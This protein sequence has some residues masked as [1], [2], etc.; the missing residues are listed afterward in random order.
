MDIEAWL[1]EDI[2]LGDVTTDAIV[3]PTHAGKGVV[4]A[5]SPLV[6]SG[7]DLLQEVFSRLSKDVRI[8]VH[9]QN[10]EF[11]AAGTVVADVEG[12]F[13]ALL[14][15]ERLALNLMM[16]LSGIATST[17]HAVDALAGSKTR[18]LDTRKTTPGLRALE[19]RAVRHGGGVNHRFG[20]FDGV[21]IKDNH[22][23]AAGGVVPAIKRARQY[24]HHLL[25]IECEIQDVAQIDEA[26]GAGADILL[27]DN[28]D[29]AT[30]VR[31]VKQ[32]DGRALTE[33]SGNMS[34]DRLPRL[35]PIGL[36][37]VSIGALTHSS[38][39]ADLSMKIA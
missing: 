15:G 16:R 22:I 19:K 17:K 12:P 4:K 29:D 5:K 3:P 21:L 24:A 8:S 13:A 33:A 6:V 25:K 23:A 37:F 2:G 7:V 34:L 11:V 35:K 26:I 27:L 14:K 28:M 39:A 10:G 31:A 30:L 36:D 9:R 38:P 18:V 20:L 1:A 32:V